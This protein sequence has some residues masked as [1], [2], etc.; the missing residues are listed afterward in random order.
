[1]KVAIFHDF[2]EVPGGGERAVLTL[3]EAFDAPIYTTNFNPRVPALLGFPTVT[4]ESIGRMPSRAPL[5]QI[6]ASLAFRRS[7][8]QGFDVYVL[9][10][11]WAHHAG[12]RHRPN[13]FYCHTPP[14]VFYDL[15]QRFVGYVTPLKRP[16][17]KAWIALHSRWDRR[18]LQYVDTIVANSENVSRRVQ[19]FYGRR[20][21]VVHPPVPVERY[22]F[23]EIGDF[24]LSV[25]RLYPEKRLELQ[26]EIFRRLP[27]ERLKVVGGYPEGDHSKPYAEGLEPPP[28]VEFLGEVSEEELRGLYAGCRGLMATGVDEDFGVTPVEAMASGKVTLAVD[29]GGYRETVQPGLTGFLIPPNAQAFVDAMRK[30][31]PDRL[32]AMKGSC[33]EAALEYDKAHFIRRMEEVLKSVVAR[34]G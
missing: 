10:G 13:V 23:S 20:A 27:A 29:E 28:N 9:S 32:A 30:L 3:A 17:A 15:Q 33:Q 5:K 22:R 25:N 26:M 6:K 19:R 2:M 12:R 8:L 7:R 24:W 21:S 31:T 14:R 11:N 1:M 18:S 34:G 16:L 4:V